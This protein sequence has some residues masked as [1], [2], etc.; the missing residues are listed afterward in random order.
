MGLT[1][2]GKTAVSLDGK[3]PASINGVGA[4][5][6]PATVTGVSAS[7]SPA[8]ITVSW[9]AVSGATSYKVYY[10]TSNSS[11]GATLAVSGVTGTSYSINGPLT[12]GTTYY[13]FVKGTNSAGDSASFSASTSATSSAPV[14]SFNTNNM[15]T[16]WTWTS[17]YDFNAN[18]GGSVIS[19][20]VYGSDAYYDPDT[21]N[22]YPADYAYLGLSIPFTSDVS[23][24]TNTFTFKVKVVSGSLA[25]TC[26]ITI[27]V[28]NIN[29][30]FRDTYSCTLTG[31]LSGG[32]YTFTSSAVV[33]I[34]T[35]LVTSG[36]NISIGFN[37]TDVGSSA[38]LQVAIDNIILPSSVTL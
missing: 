30:A 8:Q 27:D 33:F 15:G 38:V 13:C 37:S 4:A 2:D 18:G 23:P 17:V 34:A 5:S 20:V 14:L 25:T 3:T 1:I 21:E 9:S 7:N 6:L 28:P 19:P 16:D 32:W 26:H 11:S 31:S 12:T 22:D 29:P 35:Q 10:N 24:L 36:N